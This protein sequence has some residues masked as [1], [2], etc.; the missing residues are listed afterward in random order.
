ME[1]RALGPTNSRI[2][3]RGTLLTRSVTP[4]LEPAHSWLGFAAVHC[5]KELTI[6]LLGW[7]RLGRTACTDLNSNIRDLVHGSNLFSDLFSSSGLIH[8]PIRVPRSSFSVLGM[9]ARKEMNMRTMWPILRGYDMWEILLPSHKCNYEFSSNVM[10][11]ETT[12]VCRCHTGCGVPYDHEWDSHK[13]LMLRQTNCQGWRMFV[14]RKAQRHVC[15]LG[16]SWHLA[17]HELDTRPP[18]VHSLSENSEKA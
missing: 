1:T 11:K 4:G 16:V 6:L 10:K 15:F 17:Y 18:D 14:W 12:L 5:E 3:K 2:N 9:K 13:Q 8:S 7:V